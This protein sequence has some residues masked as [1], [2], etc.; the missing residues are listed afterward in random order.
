[1]KFIVDSP[2]EIWVS[3]IT[4]FKF[5][6]IFY[7]ICVI[8]DLYSRKVIAFAISKKYSTQLITSTFR[9]A[10]TNRSPQRKLTFHSDRGTQYTSF[11]FR[12]LLKFYNVTKSLSP[13]GRPK[14]NAV[15]EA[16]FS[17][18]KREELYR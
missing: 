4:Y 10:N 8:I 15:A 11:A 14:N 18:L 13:P 1:M 16:F 9:L 6:N 3:D 12:N 5:K 7:Y 2:C 17:T